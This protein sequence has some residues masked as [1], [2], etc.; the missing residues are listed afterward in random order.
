MIFHNEIHEK[1]FTEAIS[2]KN[3]ENN[4]LMAAIYLLT[5][6]DSVWKVVKPYVQRPN[7]SFRGIKL[8]ITTENGYVLYHAAK[9]LYHE[10]KKIS[11]VDIADRD[12]VQDG[13]FNMLMTAAMIK[14]YGLAAVR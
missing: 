6:E 8:R 2:L 12:Y 13:T 9:E 3:Q 11:L 10:Q 14:R 4:S 7:F 5:A 1:I